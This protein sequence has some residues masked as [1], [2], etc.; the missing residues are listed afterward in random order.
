MASVKNQCVFQFVS[1]LFVVSS[2]IAMIKIIIL[3]CLADVEDGS[4]L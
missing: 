2:Y 1:S 3:I 4:V